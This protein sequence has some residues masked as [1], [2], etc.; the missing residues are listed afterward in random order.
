[1]IKGFEKDK[2][3]K[4]GTCGGARYINCTWCQ[5]SKKSLQNP[6]SHGVNVVF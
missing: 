1:M 5:G 4:C 2:G 6:F 3:K